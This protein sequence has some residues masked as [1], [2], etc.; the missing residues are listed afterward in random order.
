MGKGLAWSESETIQLCLSWLEVSEDA[1]RGAGQ[2]KSTFSSRLYPLAGKQQ[3]TR[4]GSTNGVTSGERSGW[5]DAMYLD[6]ALRVYQD[7]HKQPLEF[8]ATWKELKCK[9]KWTNKITSA[10]SIGVKRGTSDVASV[11]R[12]DGRKAAKA[13]NAKSKG[14]Q[15][16]TAVHSIGGEDHLRFVVATE[17]KVAVMEQNFYLSIF[18]QNPASYESQE[19]FTMQ[20]KTIL[21]NMRKT[22]ADSQERGQL[23]QSEELET[24]ERAFNTP[25]V[26]G[27]NNDEGEESQVAD[28][29]TLV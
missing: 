25:H 9:P 10:S 4:Q 29:Q 28:N 3:T 13:A 15:G 19:Y 14:N 16:S 1:V 11:E 21:A 8:L 23:Q 17:K 6:A 7:R 18:L 22:L 27:L 20:R 5:N 26:A 24:P 2:K 12:P